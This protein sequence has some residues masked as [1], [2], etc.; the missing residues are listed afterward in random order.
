MMQIRRA[1]KGRNKL[2]L[3][4]IGVTGSGK[5]W[6]ALTFAAAMVEGTGLRVGLIDTERESSELYADVFDFDVISL[7]ESHDPRD[8][9]AALAAFAEA[10]NIGC[11]VIDSASHAWM[12]KGG[13]QE[14]LDNYAKKNRG[15]SFGGWREMTPLH[16]RFV[17][18]MLAA[19]FHLIVTLRAK[20]EY[21]RESDEKGKSVVRKV[22]LQPVQR[23]GMEYE[24]TV[25]VDM[26]SDH[27]LMV[28]KTRCSKVDGWV[29]NRPDGR[30]ATVLREWLENGADK[31]PAVPVVP[32][33]AF[34]APV[35]PSTPPSPVTGPATYDQLTRIGVLADCR[36]LTPVQQ[37]W[38]AGKVHST[39]TA[40][41][42]AKIINQLLALPLREDAPNEEA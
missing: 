9:I 23:D 36:V 40:D 12:G 35:A 8:Y 16:N 38:L 29:I 13:I 25:V 4:M 10:G 17:D 22:G 5:T 19:P 27:N 26:D 14:Q 33:G 18:A 39:L 11:V 1:Q 42:A 7:T 41:S 2:R 24:F 6:T 15:D 34:A 28:G 32:S 21:I 31:A 37:D 3:G 20:M 30:F